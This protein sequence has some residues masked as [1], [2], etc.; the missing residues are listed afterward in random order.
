[1]F[2]HFKIILKLNSTLVEKHRPV[3]IPASMG[4]TK[5]IQVQVRV[6]RA[7]P[8]TSVRT[9]HLNQ[10]PAQL[11]PTGRNYTAIWKNTEARNHRISDKYIYFV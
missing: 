1:M 9:Q 11:G 6:I 7:L 3:A 2:Q 10:H 5:L 8:V 4:P